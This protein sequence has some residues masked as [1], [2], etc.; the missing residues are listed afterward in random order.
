MNTL[1]Y[2][3]KD[4]RGAAP[5]FNTSLCSDM[6]TVEVVVENATGPAKIYAKLNNLQNRGIQLR[7]SECAMLSNCVA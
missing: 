3:I 6:Y 5:L 7:I 4:Q 1:T 2:T